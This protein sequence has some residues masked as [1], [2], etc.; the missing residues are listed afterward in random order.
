MTKLYVVKKISQKEGKEPFTYLQLVADLGY[1][2]QVVTMDKNVIAAL[3][4]CPVGKLY[5]VCKTLNEL[6]P[7]ATFQKIGDSQK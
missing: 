4:D 6:V 5:S 3:L 2:K 1:D 7:V